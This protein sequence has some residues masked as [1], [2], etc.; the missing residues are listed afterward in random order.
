MKSSVRRFGISLNVIIQLFLLLTLFGIVNYLSYRHYIRRD[1][2]PNKDFTLSEQTHNYLRRLSKNVNITVIFTRESPT[3]QEVRS[4]VDAYR[5][6]K[7]SRIT[8]EE[9]DPVRDMDRAEEIKLKH[10]IQLQSNGIL[11]ET[12]NRVRF[13]PESDIIIR[14][15][16][17][18]RDNPSVHFNGEDA[19][20]STIINLIEGETQRLYYITGKGEATGKG[21]ELPFIALSALGNQQNFEVLP[22]NL[23]EVTSIPED[24]SAVVI[25]GPKY[26]FSEGEMKMIEDY[27]AAER[28][29]LLILLDP[30]GQTP[31]LRQFIATQG[32]APR[33]DR[34]LV[35]ESTATGPRK[36]YSVQGTFASDSPITESLRTVTT[37]LSGQTQSLAIDTESTE[38]RARQIEVK[39]LI[40]ATDRFWGEMRYLLDL[41]RIDP[42]DTKPPVHVAASI[43]R[44]HVRD[45]RLNVDSARM[46]VVGNA[47]MLDP[48]TRLANHQDFISNSLNWM[49]N[50]DRLIGIPPKR[51]QTFRLELTSEQR[52][53]VFWVT[54][55][56]F[57]GSLLA[58]GFLVW[59]YRRA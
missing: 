27:W 48:A 59:S 17:G 23:T 22:L 54:A 57:P 49:T 2:S 40:T 20:T 3:M 32:V 45:A 39:P 25:V 51:K 4:L 47:L 24:A 12:N 53:K 44:G 21:S 38:L 9:V 41:P 34:V 5:E 43:E 50:R 58:L 13:I 29:A 6:V 16:E 37:T 30:N 7:K 15:L 10:N 56:A 1:L 26:D 19:L 33:P 35:A 14:G 11:V 42:E 31:R 18:T 28:S 36:D 55:L 46:V 52:T 8:T